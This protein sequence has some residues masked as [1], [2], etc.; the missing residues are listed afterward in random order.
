MRT[1]YTER[2]RAVAR[3]SRGFLKVTI[4]A[5]ARGG[6]A[7]ADWI[8]LI[9]GYDAR[10]LVGLVSAEFNPETVV[11]AGAEPESVASLYDLRYTLTPADF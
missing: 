9:V 8:L 11:A 4:D 6:Y 1:L 7:T 2:T 10:M 5:I 3:A